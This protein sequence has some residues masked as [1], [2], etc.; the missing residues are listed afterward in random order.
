MIDSVH[1][2]SIGGCSCV[3]DSVNKDLSIVYTSSPKA[4]LTVVI[5]GRHS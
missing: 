3:V 2:T 5:N 1:S 4:F